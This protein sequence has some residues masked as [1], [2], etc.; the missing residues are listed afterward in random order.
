MVHGQALGEKAKLGWATCLLPWCP[1]SGPEEPRRASER[2]QGV[3]C[4]LQSAP[5]ILPSGKPSTRAGPRGPE[6]K[7]KQAALLLFT[8][9][10]PGKAWVVAFHLRKP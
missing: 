4:V 1:A 8:T 3:L 5:S 9:V 7:G 2:L 6:V 10:E